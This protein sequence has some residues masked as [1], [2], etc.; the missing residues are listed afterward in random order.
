MSQLQNTLKGLTGP[1][2]YPIILLAVSPLLVHTEE[3]SVSFVKSLI[4]PINVGS[5]QNNRSR[6]LLILKDLKTQHCC[7]AKNP[8]DSTKS[9]R[10]DVS[11]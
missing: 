1:R 2:T 3:K 4:G 9:Y 7:S 10:P 6:K 5:S 11:K 8:N